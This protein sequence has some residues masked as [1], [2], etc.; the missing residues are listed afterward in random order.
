MLI[1]SPVLSRQK[2]SAAW[3]DIRPVLFL[4]GILLVGLAGMMLLPVLVDVTLHHDSSLPFLGAAASSAALG[5]LL[6]LAFRAPRP[7]LL[8][9]REGFLLSALTWIVI[10]G[11][12]SLPLTFSDAN[13]SFTDAYFEAMSGLTTTGSTIMTGLDALPQGI[14]LWRAL[15]QWLGGIGIIV[16]AVTILPYLRVGGMQFFRLE[17][18]DRTDKI[19]PRISQAASALFIIY[20]ILTFVCAFALIVVGMNPFEAVCHALATLSTGGFSTHDASIAFY[21]S[22]AIEWVIAFFML[23]GGAPFV[24]MARLFLMREPKPLLM[25]SQTHYYLLSIACF[26]AIVTLW[27]I[28]MNGRHVADALRS[29]VFFAV[30]LGTTSGFVAEDY[31]LW[32]ALPLVLAMFLLFI[33]GCTGSSSGGIKIFRFCILGSFAKW[34]L[35]SLIHPHR[36]L[37]PTY[38]GNPV[39][40]DI[41]RSVVSF[42]VFYM[43][44]FALLSMAAAAFGADFVTAFS[45]VAQALANVGHGLG[46]IIG[47][48]GN[49]AGLPSGVKWVLIIAMMLGR[50]ELMTVLVIFSPTFWRG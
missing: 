42:V 10:C 9:F 24:L 35:R 29:A 5:I 8:S 16:L 40:D 19:I 46:L 1:S 20:V 31:G 30:S 34:Q 33:G 23:C 25:D 14:L 15:L 49:F 41:T 4:I 21:N 39:T 50:L 45:G 37:L 47:P 22:P 7:L 48:T 28:G 17:Q 36:I 38:G 18:A 2:H 13:I 26:A 27:Q 43:L 32:G 6:M 44:T 3:P 11:F 12:A